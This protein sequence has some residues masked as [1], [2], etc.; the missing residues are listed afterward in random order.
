LLCLVDLVDPITGWKPVPLSPLRW[1]RKFLWER[2]GLTKS[3]R[4][5]NNP[6][7]V[8]KCGMMAKGGYLICENTVSLLVAVVVGGVAACLSGSA[9]LGL[10]RVSHN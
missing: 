3:S 10:K 4:L 6:E 2:A 1:L 5:D 9:P 7:K 8:K